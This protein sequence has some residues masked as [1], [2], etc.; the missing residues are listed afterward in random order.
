MKL[1][2]V[3]R[4]NAFSLMPS[5]IERESLRLEKTAEKRF[6]RRLRQMPGLA[7]DTCCSAD[8]VAILLRGDNEGQVAFDRATGCQPVYQNS[9]TGVYRIEPKPSGAERHFASAS[10]L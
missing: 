8:F 4:S 10:W 3:E 5:P 2:T 6:A 1:K 7:R 9:A